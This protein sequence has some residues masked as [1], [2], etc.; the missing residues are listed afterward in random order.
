MLTVINSTF[1]GNRGTNGALFNSS[2]ATANVGGTIFANNSFFNCV[3]TITNEGFNI[4][5][6]ASCN[7]G[8]TTGANGHT[9]G[10]SVSDSNIALAPLG[11]Y[12]G[13]TQT[14]ALLPNSFA[15]D[16][17]P[18]AQPCPTTDQRGVTRPDQGETACDVGA[19]E[20]QDGAGFTLN[21]GATDGDG[22]QVQH[23]DVAT[24]VA[25]SASG[26]GG[27][28]NSGGS[29]DALVRIANASHS[30]T[31]QNGTLCAMIYVFDD[32]EEQQACCGCP[33]T[34]DGLRSLSVINDLTSNLGVNGANRSAGVIEII[35]SPLNFKYNSGTPVVP[36]INKDTNGQNF[37]CDPS[38]AQG[39]AIGAGTGINV[40]IPSPGMRAWENHTESIAPT[41]PASGFVTALS[42]EKF[43]TSTLDGSEAIN[44]TTNCARQFANGS[45][46]GVCTC[47]AGDN[48]SSRAPRSSNLR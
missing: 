18:L 31:T 42:E 34:P 15:I 13:P 33:V 23:F 9:I 30:D 25:P 38:F 22:Y 24:H 28:G 16:A 20:F 10:D 3:G 27:P 44:L 1:S 40:A 46:T 35:T 26:Y 8:S 6:D 14:I 17:V 19:Y 5:D 21:I 41:A 45:G 43:A 39:A 48:A 7:F 36:G 37:A 12:G 2:G 32:N 47:G 11:N 4:A 29:G